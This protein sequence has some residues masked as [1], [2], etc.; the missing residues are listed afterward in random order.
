MLLSESKYREICEIRAFDLFELLE[1]TFHLTDVPASI[2]DRKM[3]ARP[4]HTAH[5]ILGCLSFV[6]SLFKDRNT[7]IWRIENQRVNSS[8]SIAL[9]VVPLSVVTTLTVVGFSAEQKTH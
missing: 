3:D 7:P 6:Q 9:S 1:F 4:F 5:N 2:Y 8:L